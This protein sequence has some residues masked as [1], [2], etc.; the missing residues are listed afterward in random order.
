MEPHLMLSPHPN[1]ES[2][3]S[4]LLAQLQRIERAFRVSEALPAERGIAFN[5][6]TQGEANL[7]PAEQSRC[8]FKKMLG[9]PAKILAYHLVEKLIASFWTLVETDL[10]LREPGTAPLATVAQEPVNEYFSTTKL[11]RLFN[12]TP[13]TQH[14]A[15]IS[16]LMKDTLSVW[17]SSLGPRTRVLSM[18]GPQVDTMLQR[19]SPGLEQNSPT[20]LTSVSIALLAALDSN[21]DFLRDVSTAIHNTFEVEDRK[22]RAMA[23]TVLRDAAHLH[24]HTFIALT[25]ALSSMPV[26]QTFILDRSGKLIIHDAMFSRVADELAQLGRRTPRLGCPATRAV[27]TLR[28]GREVRVLGRYLSWIASVHEE[29]CHNLGE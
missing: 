8:P 14:P 19:L 6:L 4:P 7:F 20:I 25:I 18:T 1:I 11:K 22:A 26:S 5:V 10:A 29:C 23:L 2:R 21:Q 13:A 17:C 27:A 16:G 9:A 28:N 24:V 15:L 3:T 12:E